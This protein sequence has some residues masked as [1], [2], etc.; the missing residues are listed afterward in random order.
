MLLVSNAMNVKCS[1][2]KIVPAS[3]GMARHIVKRTISGKETTFSDIFYELLSEKIFLST[4][5]ICK[6]QQANIQIPE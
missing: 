6:S 2:T 3:F 1:W 5:K 4:S